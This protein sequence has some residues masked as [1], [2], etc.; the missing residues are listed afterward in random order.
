MRAAQLL[1]IFLICAIASALMWWF[2]GWLGCAPLERLLWCFIL[3]VFLATDGI[4]TD[5]WRLTE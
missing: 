4:A 2:T 3:L 5:V 1:V